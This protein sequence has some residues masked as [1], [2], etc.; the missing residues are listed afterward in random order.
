[1]RLKAKREK[2][3]TLSKTRELVRKMALSFIVKFFG[4]ELNKFLDHLKESY[5][6]F[7]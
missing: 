4:S 7:H 2:E 5:P 1:M 3:L 6:G